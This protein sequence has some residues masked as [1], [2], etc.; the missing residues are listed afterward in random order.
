MGGSGLGHNSSQYLRW[1]CE[2]LVVKV[3][4]VA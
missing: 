4:M 3:C 1:S 2:G